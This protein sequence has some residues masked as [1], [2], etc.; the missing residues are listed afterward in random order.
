MAKTAKASVKT[1]IRRTGTKS[2][3]VKTTTSVNGTSKTTTKTIRAK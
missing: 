3:Q 2:V 1:S